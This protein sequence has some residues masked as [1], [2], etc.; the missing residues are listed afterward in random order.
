MKAVAPFIECDVVW[1]IA[2]FVRVLG[3]DRGV[4]ILVPCPV[5]DDFSHEFVKWLHPFTNAVNELSNGF[6]VLCAFA[7]AFSKGFTQQEL[8]WCAASR[9]DV[10]DDVL[11]GKAVSAIDVFEV[12]AFNAFRCADRKHIVG[13]RLFYHLALLAKDVALDLINRAGLAFHFRHQNTR[14]RGDHHVSGKRVQ[15]RLQRE[16]A[17]LID[18]ASDEAKACTFIRNV[19]WRFIHQNANTRAMVRL[20]ADGNA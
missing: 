11:A 14:L 20:A 13:L 10:L 15:E 16:Q 18:A 3:L 19:D 2:I 8:G 17:A 12:E 1:N 9:R 5:H 6:C 4:E 7:K